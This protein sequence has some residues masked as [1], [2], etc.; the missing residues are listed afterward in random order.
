M[1][2]DN[3]P[4]KLDSRTVICQANFLYFSLCMDL[5]SPQHTYWRLD[6]TVDPTEDMKKN[7]VIFGV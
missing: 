6:Y 4:F 3:F 2:K 1:L 5:V 7:R